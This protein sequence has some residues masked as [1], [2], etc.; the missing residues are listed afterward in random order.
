MG[1]L[2]AGINL[3][4]DIKGIPYRGIGTGV[5]RILRECKN[6]GINVDFIE[7]KEAEQFKVIFFRN[8]E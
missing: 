7:E 2:D 1:I 5:Q 8:V 4:K 3:L 6:A